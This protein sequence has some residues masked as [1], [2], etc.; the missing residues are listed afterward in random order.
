MACSREEEI[1]VIRS[2]YCDAVDIFETVDDT[3]FIFRSHPV[4][5]FLTLPLS[6][7]DSTSQSLEIMLDSEGLGISRLQLFELQMRLDTIIQSKPDEPVLFE[8]FEET[9]EFTQGLRQDIETYLEEEEEE[10]DEDIYA[11]MDDLER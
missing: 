8:L 11:D 10:I 4:V 2:I 6:Y 9:R 1:E 3:H 7:P 5:L